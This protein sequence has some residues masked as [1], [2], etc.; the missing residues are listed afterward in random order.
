[1]PGP[2]HSTLLLESGK[3]KVKGWTSR[4]GFSE[5]KEEHEVKVVLECYENA[6]VLGGP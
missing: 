5:I 6:Q 1:M 3:F 2:S 4:R